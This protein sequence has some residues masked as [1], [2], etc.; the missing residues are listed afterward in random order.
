MLLRVAL[1]VPTCTSVS[2][3]LTRAGCSSMF[4]P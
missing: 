4:Y 1:Q 2:T 3:L